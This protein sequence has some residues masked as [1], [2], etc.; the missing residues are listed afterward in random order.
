MIAER[1]AVMLPTLTGLRGIAALAVLFYHIRLAM[2]GFLPEAAIALLAHGYLAVD[3]FF[4][5]SGFVLWWNYGAG[6]AAEG[7][8]AAPRFLVRRIARIFP[9]HLA[10]LSAMLAFAAA[11]IVSGRDPGAQYDFA[12][13]PAHYLLVQNWGVAG[14]LGWNIPAW[15]ISTEWAAYLLLAATGGLFARL[16]AGR[17]AFP[18]FV[19]IVALALGGWF[20]ATGRASIGADIAATGLLRCLAEF[21]MG[22][23][24]CRWWSGERERADGAR[25]I[26]AIAGGFALLAAALLVAGLPQPMAIPIIMVAVVIGGLQASMAARPALS[27]RVAQWLGD[28]SYA[29]YLSHFFLWILFKLLFIDDLAA[30]SPAT[31]AAFVALTLAV[32]HGLHIGLEIPARR[33]VQRGG[34]A[35]LA[36]LALKYRTRRPQG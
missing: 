8:R 17:I 5:L 31:I 16:P 23:A 6:F 4:V 30:V 1:K 19:V 18:A 10:I 35:L 24:L 36:A 33:I 9:L 3:L 29:V 34:D 27:G 14:E 28:I 15:S 13:L 32:S 25:V 11:L 21:A 20:A 7:H 26:Y 22:I 12:M 2:T